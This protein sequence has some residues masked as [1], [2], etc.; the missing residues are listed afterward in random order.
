MSKTRDTE[1]SINISRP[2][3]CLPDSQ[4]SLLKD[5]GLRLDKADSCIYNQIKE[6][7]NESRVQGHDD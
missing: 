7:R 2:T 3:R 5:Y 4:Y 1:A 6:T